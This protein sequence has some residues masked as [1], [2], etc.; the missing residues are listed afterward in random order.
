MRNRRFRSGALCLNQIKPKFELD[1]E[2]GLVTSICPYNFTESNFLIEEWML[3]VNQS[4]A[5]RLSNY[6]PQTAFLRN[7]LPPFSNK[8]YEV[9][10]D[11]SEYG[12]DI[13]TNSG[14]SI[15]VSNF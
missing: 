8:L 3:A 14:Y 11:L 15:Q 7:H 12:I 5:R 1:N 2:T 10:N 6:F 13:D 4:V 9:S